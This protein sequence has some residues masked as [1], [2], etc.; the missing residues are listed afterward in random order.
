MSPWSFFFVAKST[1][2]VKILQRMNIEKGDQKIRI[3]KKTG[4][5]ILVI[6]SL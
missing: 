4:V 1:I 6:L 3:M 5:K 2:K